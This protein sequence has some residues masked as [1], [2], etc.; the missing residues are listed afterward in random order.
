[1]LQFAVSKG[2]TEPLVSAALWPTWACG[3]AQAEETACAWDQIAS[4]LLLTL[5]S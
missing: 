1:M 4:Q 5:G 2:V 3:V